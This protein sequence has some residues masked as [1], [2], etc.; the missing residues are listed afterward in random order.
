LPLSGLAT[1]EFRFATWSIRSLSLR[2]EAF[3]RVEKFSRVSL[4]AM[5][6]SGTPRLFP[7]S[8]TPLE[9][10][11]LADVRASHPMTFW[12]YL[13]LAGNV[14]AEKIQTAYCAALRRH[15]L[16][17]AY[18]RPGRK[19]RLYWTEADDSAARI[20]WL[21]TDEPIEFTADERIDLA[22]EPGLRMWIERGEERTRLSLEFH[23]ACCDGTGAY[24][25]IGDLLAFYGQAFEETAE[26]S[27]VE[28]CETSQL[29]G[30]LGLQVDLWRTRRYFAL[31]KRGFGQL[32]ALVRNRPSQLRGRRKPGSAVPVRPAV[33][34]AGMTA[35]DSQSLRR[36]AIASSATL[37]DL[38]IAALFRTLAAWNDQVGKRSAKSFARVMMPVDLRT[39]DE[40]G[41]P[42]AC[43]T[44][45]T[46]L[47]HRLGECVDRVKILGAVSR[48]TAVIKSSAAAMVF[49]DAV[50]IAG[51]APKVLPLV[52]SA[53]LSL[54][55]AV[56]S[57]PG[58]PSR[59]F[60]ATLPRRDGLIVSG[61]L[62]LKE[63]TGV[64]PLRPRTNATFSVSGYGKR[65][66][67]SLR[68]H[69]S[70]FDADDARALLDLY[71]A[72]LTA[73]LSV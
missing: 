70:A 48:D 43:L 52:L 22:V 51:S 42:A 9:K 44:S 72:S 21:A 20:T 33:F 25:F 27:T 16:L 37:N 62:V 46:F 31:A 26:S 56:L 61:N 10:F 55:S 53:P 11:F 57:N 32:A 34:F 49:A 67:V 30:R 14:D 47:T 68:C 7:L 23:H 6:E 13:E 65:L 5:A 36:V 29:R 35:A 2:I 28:P 38:L 4:Q 39:G 60:T 40:R 66:T 54:A 69:H 63:I 18:A 59:R 1:L 3:V 41:M 8:L 19:G 12:V 24:R 45:Y 15:P 71:M 58:D 17:R 50:A 73:Y 64:P